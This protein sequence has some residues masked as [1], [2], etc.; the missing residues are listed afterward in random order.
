[1]VQKKLKPLKG[2]AA[3][4]KSREQVIQSYENYNIK[5]DI[6]NQ[7]DYERVQSAY[8]SFY[9]GVDPRRKRE[10]AD[11]GIVKED[12]NAMSNLSGVGYQKQFPRAGY[13][14]NPYIQDS[15]KKINFDVE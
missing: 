6:K 1:M 4:V 3:K 2:S 7:Y 13:Y 12:R 9:A 10:M 15:V 11:A 5:Q 14:A 8:S